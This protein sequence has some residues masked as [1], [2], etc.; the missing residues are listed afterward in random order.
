MSPL[1]NFGFRISNF[2]SSIDPVYMP[3]QIGKRRIQ[4]EIRNPK[5]LFVTQRY[6]RIDLGCAARRDVAGQQRHH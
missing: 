3:S 5:F 2:E 1:K 6:Q 4:S